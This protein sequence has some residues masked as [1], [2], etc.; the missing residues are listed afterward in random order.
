MGVCADNGQVNV[1]VVWDKF[2]SAYVGVQPL[3]IKLGKLILSSIN[4]SA[5]TNVVNGN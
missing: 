1:S 5:D 3:G 4:K 2:E